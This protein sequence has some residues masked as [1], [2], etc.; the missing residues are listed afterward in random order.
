MCEID[1]KRRDRVHPSLRKIPKKRKEEQSSHRTRRRRRGKGVKDDGGRPERAV[2]SGED[3]RQGTN[4]G[5]P[6]TI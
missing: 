1:M 4:D 6:L 5:Y 3:R 2:H